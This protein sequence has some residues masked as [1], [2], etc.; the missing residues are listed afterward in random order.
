MRG[1][2]SGLPYEKNADGVWVPKSPDE[3]TFQKI[4]EKAG[5]IKGGQGFKQALLNDLP[6]SGTSK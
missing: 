2:V 4:F 1:V 5:M 6:I 3:K